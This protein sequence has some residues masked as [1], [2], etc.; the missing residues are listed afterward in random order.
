MKKHT[1]T[2]TRSRW[3][4]MADERT[5][6]YVIDDFDEQNPTVSVTNDADAVIQAL[7]AIQDLT[8]KRVFYRDTEGDW[9]ELLHNNGVFNGFGFLSTPDQEAAIRAVAP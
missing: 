4:Y 7:A 1:I 9:D 2:G 6:I 3:H 5:V 8:G